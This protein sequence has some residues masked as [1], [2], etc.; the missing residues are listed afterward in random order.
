[1][2]QQHNIAVDYDPAN[3][4]QAKRSMCFGNRTEYHPNV[5]TPP[6]LRE[7]EIPAEYSVNSRE[8]HGTLSAQVLMLNTKIFVSF[9]ALHRCM[10]ESITYDFNIPTL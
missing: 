3:A 7:Y 6:I 4:T 2:P 8:M 10:N 9:Q 1:M 5:D